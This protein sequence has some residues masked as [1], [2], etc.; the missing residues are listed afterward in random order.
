MTGGAGGSGGASTGAANN[1]NGGKGGA[2]LNVTGTGNTITIGASSVLTGG[3]AGV[4]GVGGGGLAGLNGATGDALDLFGTGT[5]LINN[6]TINGRIQEGSSSVAS[7]T[8]TGTLSGILGVNLASTGTTNTIGSLNSTT[9]LNLS[10]E[11]VDVNIMGSGVVAT[12]TSH[13]VTLIGGGNE[14]VGDVPAA[15]VTDNSLFYNFT[16]APGSGSTA[17]DLELIATLTPGLTTNGNNAGGSQIL[18]GNLAGSANP[19]IILIQNNLLSAPS[20]AAFNNDLEATLPTVDGG[21][22]ITAMNMTEGALDLTEDRIA[23]IRTGNETGMAAG[24]AGTGTGLWMQGF[25]QH[26]NQDERDDVK[27]YSANTW[28]GA[29]GLDTAN[30]LDHSLFGIDFSYGRSDVSSDNAN[31]TDTRINSYQATLYGTQNL[32]HDMFVNGMVAYAWDRDTTVRHDVGGVPGLEADGKYSASQAAA[33]LAAGRD[34]AMDGITLTPSLVGDYMYFH[35][36]S[37]TETGA[38]GANLNVK[39]GNFSQLDLGVN[40]KAGWTFK[41]TGGGVTKPSIHA[42]YR[43]NVLNDNV[44]ATSS[45]TGGGGDFTTD[46][47]TPGRSIINAGADIKFV[48]TAKWEFSASYDFE[49]KSGYTANAGI[50]R[51]TYKF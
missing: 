50:V 21:N 16:I 26:A 23:S 51:A 48:T 5:I 13:Q 3:A 45:F 40:L 9:A 41:N 12:G 20:K 29:L 22:L 36:Q 42:G 38:G 32:G 27:G 24:D 49:A 11:T 46:G 2:A 14:V 7:I 6:G 39:Y 25:G 31:S 17:G 28:G 10:G 19:Q 44:Q 18:L 34:F 43:Y 4:A 47:L 8:N 33:R 37:Y 30:T 15:A 35:P 1:S